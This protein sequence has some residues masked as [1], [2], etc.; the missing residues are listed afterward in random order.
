MNRMFFSTQTLITSSL[1]CDPRLSPIKPNGLSPSKFLIKMSKKTF[2]KCRAIKPTRLGGV[3]YCVN[4]TTIYPC[5]IE[6]LWFLNF[7]WR[8]HFSRGW[9]TKHNR[10]WCF[11]TFNFSLQFL[12]L[13]TIT[14]CVKFDLLKV[15][16]VGEKMILL[17]FLSGLTR[18]P[19]CSS[20][21]V[22]NNLL[23][24]KNEYK[25]R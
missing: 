8:E 3:I 18:L 11:R 1:K 22:S 14:Y 16:F 12:P 2:F 7:H 10:S 23:V 5:I 9:T 19:E 20:I 13:L 17:D 6:E 25:F 24:E 15:L 4:K 21:I